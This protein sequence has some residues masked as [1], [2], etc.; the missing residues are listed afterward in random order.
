MELT[1]YLLLGVWSSITDLH[2]RRIPNLSV[3]VFATT[4]LIF[5]NFGF[6]YLLL[7]TF[8]LS[9]L[10]YLSRA[11]LGY[12]D[13]KLSMVLALHCTTC[14]ELI[15]ALL[16]SFSSAALALCVIALIRRTWPKSLPFAPYLWLGFLTSL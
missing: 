12:G 14:A 6:R 1:L 15:S 2:T 10:R 13:I 4:F 16:F 5:D 9:I 3:L 8:V 7:A 11:G